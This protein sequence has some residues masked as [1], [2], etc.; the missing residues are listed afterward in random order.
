M[1]H[2]ALSWTLSRGWCSAEA[3][4]V[5]TK[6]VSREKASGGACLL[7]ANGRPGPA[8]GDRLY[9]YGY[10]YNKKDLEADS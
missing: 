7:P 2:R 6:S 8:N 9:A 5:R 3:E 4:V 1:P 10:D